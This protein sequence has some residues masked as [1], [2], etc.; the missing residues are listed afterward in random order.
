MNQDPDQ[1]RFREIL[2]RRPLTAAEQAEL[3]KWLHTHPEAQQEF[4][5][6][7]ILSGSLANLPEAPVPSNFTTR[8]LQAVAAEAHSKARGRATNLPW[9]QLWL[10]RFAAIGLVVAVCLGGWRY[11]VQQQDRWGELVSEVATAPVLA[12]PSVLADF[13]E[14]YRLIPAEILPDE[15]LL[16]MSDDLLA[17]NE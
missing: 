17:L 3:Q 12:N 5:T 7:T 14:V 4:E 8:V 16:A 1:Q 10:P 6:D 15:S 9:W 13:E 11:H 2:W